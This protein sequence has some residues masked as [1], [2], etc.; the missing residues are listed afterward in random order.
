MTLVAADDCIKSRKL[1]GAPWAV[2]YVF[3]KK[4]ENAS[5][6]LRLVAS[7]V[8]AYNFAD[9][10][11]FPVFGDMA[12]SALLWHAEFR[13]MWPQHLDKQ[14]RRWRD[15][16]LE[17]LEPIRRLTYEDGESEAIRNTRHLQ[18]IPLHNG[19]DADCWRTDVKWEGENGHPLPAGYFYGAQW[20]RIKNLRRST[21]R[22]VPR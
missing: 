6:K 13:G 14:S 1:V 10:T 20:D 12:V 22:P 4:I 19:G 9:C 17:Y 18:H 3:G 5:I 21:D 16:M 11:G 8:S 7:P 2:A 15:G